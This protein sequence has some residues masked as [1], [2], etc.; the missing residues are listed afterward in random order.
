MT[1]LRIIGGFQN[2]ALLLVVVLAG[3]APLLA[4]MTRALATVA[5]PAGTFVESSSLAQ[6]K[7][8]Y[9][10]PTATAARATTGGTTTRRQSGRPP[11]G[12]KIGD[13]GSKRRAL[14]FIPK[15]KAAPFDRREAH[16][17]EAD[18]WRT[19]PDGGWSNGRS[20]ARGEPAT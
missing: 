15:E 17:P 2:R 12:K 6:R 11:A 5:V 18:P 3:G 16:C 14:A 4:T 7:Y 8:N 20:D 1:L 13:R 19:R 9:A 10:G